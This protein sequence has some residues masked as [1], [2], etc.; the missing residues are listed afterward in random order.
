M[1]SFGAR[2]NETDYIKVDIDFSSGE[3]EVIMTTEV[4]GTPITATGA[5][6]WDEIGADDNNDGDGGLG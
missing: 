3:N 4:E 6:T 1:A 5:I 2:F